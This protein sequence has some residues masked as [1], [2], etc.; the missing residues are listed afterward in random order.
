M[1][2]EPPASEL[3]T[4]DQSTWSVIAV[5]NNH[6]IIEDKQGRRGASELSYPKKA[7]GG[8]GLIED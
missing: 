2:V 6:F 4:P 8:G 1:R 5:T 7:G 3:T